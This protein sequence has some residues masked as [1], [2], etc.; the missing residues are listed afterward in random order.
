MENVTN[1]FEALIFVRLENVSN[2]PSV[3]K[4]IYKENNHYEHLANDGEKQTTCRLL[5]SLHLPNV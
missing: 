3:E 2:S 1:G 4:V 5:F